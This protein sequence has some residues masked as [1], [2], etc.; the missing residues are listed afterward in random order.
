MTK[1]QLAQLEAIKAEI[2]KLSEGKPNEYDAILRDAINGDVS[3]LRYLAQVFLPKRATD[4]EY[5]AER[6]AEQAAEDALCG[7]CD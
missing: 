1:K 3:A 2:A 6:R 7:F 5:L 4:S